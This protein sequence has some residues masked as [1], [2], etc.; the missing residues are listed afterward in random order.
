MESCHDYIQWVFPLD[1]ES[2]SVPN[3]PILTTEDIK[4]IKSSPIAIS[5]LKQSA[6]WFFQFLC[7]N[8]QWLCMTNHNHLRITRLI[9][10]LRILAGD[11]A[12][13][14]IRDKIMQFA[15][16]SGITINVLTL[17]FWAHS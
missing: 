2:G 9:K 12:A 5:N 8:D 17:E 15:K 4:E 1:Q 13:N 3:A 10:S 16:K 6:D 11:D 14:A 7:R